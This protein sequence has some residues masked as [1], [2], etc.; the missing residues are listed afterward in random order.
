MEALAHRWDELADALA[1]MARDL[2]NQ[3]SLQATLDAIV[4]HAV[5]LVPGCEAAGILE[6]RGGKLHTLSATD[7]VALVSDRVQSETGEGPCLDAT[8]NRERVYR[9]KDLEATAI[10]W[11]RYTPRAR[12]L[13]IGSMM[14]LLL[15]TNG[16]DNHGALNLYSSEPA[17]F[18]EHCEHVGLL[19][20]AH[21]AVTLAAARQETNLRQA[22]D[23]SRRIGEAI[24][25]VMSRYRITEVEAFD[26][27][28]QHSQQHNIKVRN[29]AED[30]L[31]SGELPTPKPQRS[32]P[33]S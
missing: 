20:A 33:G 19:L 18:N 5:D 28:V 24:G 6:R 25:V 31:Q 29:L 27:L 9:I 12:E 30:I 26:R 23:T 15:Y 4:T 32:R 8:R 22:L 3:S 21:A 17:A 7:N 1:Q 13:G 10:Q 16:D 14:G 2:L 11:P